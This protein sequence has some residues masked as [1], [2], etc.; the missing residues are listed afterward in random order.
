MQ[1]QYLSTQPQE[2]RTLTAAMK[3]LQKR[4]VAGP[5]TGCWT[6]K[7]PCIDKKQRVRPPAVTHTQ[8]NKQKKNKY[9]QTQSLHVGMYDC[10]RI[11]S[12]SAGAR[13]N[14][15]HTRHHRSPRVCE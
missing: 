10:M 6:K 9:T 13:A 8:K 15:R 2:T 1:A 4:R 3:A 12:E 11:E 7:D 5:T 14:Q